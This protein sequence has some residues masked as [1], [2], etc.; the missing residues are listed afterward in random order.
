MYKKNGVIAGAINKII[1]LEV[2]RPIISSIRLY[3]CDEQGEIVSLP[4]ATQ[5]VDLGRSKMYA[6]MLIEVLL[7]K[8]ILL[9]L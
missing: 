5:Y 6:L 7:Q 8:S 1:W 4:H 3:I 9:Y 2:V